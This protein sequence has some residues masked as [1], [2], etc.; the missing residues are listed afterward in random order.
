MLSETLGSLWKFLA[1]EC[2]LDCWLHELRAPYCPQAYMRELVKG[3][4]CIWL[5]HHIWPIRCSWEL[6]N[7]NIPCGWSYSSSSEASCQV[8]YGPFRISLSQLNSELSL[9]CGFLG[10]LLVD[11]SRVERLMLPVAVSQLTSR[12]DLANFSQTLLLRRIVFKMHLHMSQSWCSFYDN[13]P[14]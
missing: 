8:T 1:E 4:I 10:N 7:D 6:T 5:R 2:Y 13:F 11:K 9:P 14:L 3:N 12:N